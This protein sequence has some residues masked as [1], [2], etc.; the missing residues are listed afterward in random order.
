MPETIPPFGISVPCIGDIIDPT[1]FGTF[2]ASVESAIAAVDLVGVKA[3]RRPGVLVASTTGTPFVTG[4]PV[5]AG[6]NQEIFDTD[7][8]WTLVAPTLLTIQTAGSYLVT[9]VD[10]SNLINTDTSLKTEILLNGNPI[11][12]SKTGSGVAGVGAPSPAMVEAFAPQLIVG[13]QLSLRVTV[14]GVGNN[15]TFPQFGA[16]LIS[17]GGS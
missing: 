17:Y 14:T 10:S 8:M 6:F 4:V 5:V 13:D 2:A 7:N 16:T 11:S 9:A 15:S 3:L 12:T 1:V